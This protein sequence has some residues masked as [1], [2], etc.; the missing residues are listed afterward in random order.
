MPLREDLR[1]MLPKMSVAEKV[2][3]Y[4]QMKRRDYYMQVIWPEIE[5]DVEALMGQVQPSPQPPSPSETVSIS[6]KSSTS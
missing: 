4:Q 3:L 5:A 2:E 6:P 1:Q